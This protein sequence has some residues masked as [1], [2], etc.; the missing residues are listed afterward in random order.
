LLALPV[1]AAL[2]AA[3]GSSA[4]SS[5]HG[6][7]QGDGSTGD[8]GP[9]LLG[10][11]GASDGPSGPLTIAPANPAIAVAY[12]AHTPEVGFTAA[13]GGVPVRAS[14]SIDPGAIGVVDASTGILTPSGLVGGLA[15]VTARW[16]A[17]TATTGVT[18]TV[19]RSPSA[20]GGWSVDR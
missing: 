7:N 12:G 3:C 9:D 20:R 19:E 2:G 17:Q 13:V 18:V 16:G 14:F 15:H 1:V 11:A 5:W 6:G 8:D 10:D 4:G